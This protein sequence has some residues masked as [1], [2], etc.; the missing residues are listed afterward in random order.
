MESIQ[1]KERDYETWL[2]NY[3]GNS[4][5]QYVKAWGYWQKYLGRK[6]EA[7]IFANKDTEDW[8]THLVNFHRWLKQQPK[9]RGTGT[10]SDNTAKSYANGIR[11]YF[12]HIGIVV[13]LDRV[14]KTEITNVESTPTIDYPFNLQV[15]ERL[16]SV[17]DPKEA[18]IVSAGVSFG[19][20]VGDFRELTRGLLEPLLD[21]EV[22]IQLPRLM[23][24]KEGI[25][26]YPL[27]DRDA[28]EAIGSL[29]R[30][31]DK[32]GRTGSADKMLTLTS[33][34]ITDAL[35]RLFDRA[36]VNVGE[37]QVRFHILRK[38]LTDNLAAVCSG[39]KWKHFVGKKATS[40][41][42]SSEGKKAY[43]KVMEFTCVNHR[44]IGDRGTAVLRAEVLELSQQV[45]WIRHDN[46]RVG[47]LLEHLVN[48]VLTEGQRIRMQKFVKEHFGEE[49]P[50]DEK[51]Q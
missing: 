12:R 5:R 31:M 40:P 49:Y 43:G 50:M 18:Y 29:L 36:G 11:G 51:D 48:N 30:E 19:L 24:K 2:A 28:K 42:V 25:P 39:D 21:K 3:Q 8:A 37:Y 38:F 33:R 14:Q 9:Q 23:T 4:L 13:E 35:K 6:D 1:K 26:A 41:Y 15:K 27:I 34:Q 45:D 10:L 47:A 44:G 22:P 7:W 16:L 46:E 32:E 17:A 20:R